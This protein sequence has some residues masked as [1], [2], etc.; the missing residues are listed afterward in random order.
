[1]FS[2]LAHAA[3]SLPG[4]ALADDPAYPTMSSVQFVHQQRKSWRTERHIKAGQSMV[5]RDVQLQWSF[6]STAEWTS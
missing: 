1:M 2:L 5:H 6:D 4:N 3:A